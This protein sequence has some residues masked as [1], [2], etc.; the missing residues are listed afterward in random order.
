MGI[1]WRRKAA[2]FFIGKTHLSN[3]FI[4][5]HISP[6]LGRLS[7]WP[8][9]REM[10][11]F[12]IERNRRGTIREAVG[13]VT[14]SYHCRQVS[15]ER[16]RRTR[17]SQQENSHEIDAR[18]QTVSHLCSPA[19][20]HRLRKL[21]FLGRKIRRQHSAFFCGSIAHC[22]WTLLNPDRRN[23]ASCTCMHS[24]SSAQNQL[25]S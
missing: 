7:A 19:K 18:R 22:S 15:Y 20:R 12:L 9:Q 4:S 25:R 17:V 21:I 5:F 1:L 23:K 11:R 13:H 24:N 10:K 8:P 2:E 3:F 16:I 14:I 6:A